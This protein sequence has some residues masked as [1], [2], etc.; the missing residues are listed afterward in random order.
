M[1]I[2]DGCQ[3]GGKLDHRGIVTGLSHDDTMDIPQ[4]SHALRMLIL[5]KSTRLRIFKLNQINH[6]FVLYRI[7]FFFV[8]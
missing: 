6:T 8:D 7:T 5:N 4:S 1:M 2:P 3:P